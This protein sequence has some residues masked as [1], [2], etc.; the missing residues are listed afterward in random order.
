MSSKSARFRLSTANSTSSITCLRSNDRSPAS[1]STS[2]SAR[3]W[4]LCGAL[5]GDDAEVSRVLLARE[6]K[7]KGIDPE[8]YPLVRTLGRIS[9]VSVLRAGAGDP[10]RGTWPVL[11]LAVEEKGLRSLEKIAKALV[12]HGRHLRLHWVLEAEFQERLVFVL[13]PGLVRSPGEPGARE[14]LDARAD[15]QTIQRLVERDMGLAWWWS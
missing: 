4:I 10:A 7:E 3:S 6:A 9:R 13:K 5:S 14:V 8:V 12:L 2:Y 15:L 11:V 1:G